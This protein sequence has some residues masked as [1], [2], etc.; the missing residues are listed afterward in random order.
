MKTIPSLDKLNMFILRD[1]ARINFVNEVR[2][3]VGSNYGMD[4][5]NDLEHDLAQDFMIHKVDGLSF[6]ESR[7]LL[8]ELIKEQMKRHGVYDKARKYWWLDSLGVYKINEEGILV[9]TC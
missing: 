4:L 1:I 8:E 9:S 3:T 7:H 2:D 5:V 6:P